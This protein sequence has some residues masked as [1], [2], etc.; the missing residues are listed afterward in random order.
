MS[1]LNLFRIKDDKVSEIKSCSVTLEI[2]LQRIIEGNMFEFFGVRFL[3]SEYYIKESKD[4]GYDVT[5]ALEELSF[6]NQGNVWIFG[7]PECSLAML[8]TLKM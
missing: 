4:D 3:A 1:N 6:V 7:E 8:L 2:E 5:K